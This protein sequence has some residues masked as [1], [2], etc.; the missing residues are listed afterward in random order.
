MLHQVD[1]LNLVI[2]AIIIWNTVYIDKVVQQLRKEGYEIS[3]DDLKSV[4]PT[5][6]RHLNVYGAYLYETERIG[7]QLGLRHLRQPGPQP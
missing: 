1:C 5:R 3:D 2:N 4:W 6:Q 7:Q